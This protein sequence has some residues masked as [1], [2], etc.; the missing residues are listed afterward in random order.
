MADSLSI[1][2]RIRDEHLNIRRHIKLVGD[3]VADIEAMSRLERAR[4]DWVPGRP[5]ALADK[6]KELRQTLSF[7]DEGLGN[8]FAIEENE[9]P[10]LAGDL[11]MR[12]LVID[13]REIMAHMNQAKSLLARTVIE[14]LP[15]EDVLSKGLQ[16][17]Q[18]IEHLRGLIEDHAN[19]EETLLS[20]LETA[21]QND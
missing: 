13:H 21:L 4:A 6:Q 3:S 8:H 19:R 17:Q 5:T 2:K 7:L 18:A 9:L 16:I 20:M 15:R 10:A 12:A 1:I 11:F 14:D